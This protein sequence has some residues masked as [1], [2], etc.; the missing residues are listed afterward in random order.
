MKSMHFVAAACL[1]L[2]VSMFASGCSDTDTHIPGRFSELGE[3]CRATNDCVK[4]TACLQG[5]CV[6]AEFPIKNSA[7]ECAVIE[8]EERAD[9]NTDKRDN[10]YCSERWTLCDE[11]QNSAACYDYNRLCLDQRDCREERCVSLVNRS[12]VTTLT[13]YSGNPC[14]FG[15]SCVANETGSTLGT[16]TPDD[17]TE[18]EEEEE[19]ARDTECPLFNECQE[20]ECVRVG[21]QSD[22]E[23]ASSLRN[24]RAIC[25]KDTGKCTTPCTNDA[26]CNTGTSYSFM[27]CVKKECVYLGCESDEECRGSAQLGSSSNNLRYEC[28]KP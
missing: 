28:R 1:L 5:V 10:E 20:G 22:R 9:C 6:A 27:G 4:D 14:D 7:K 23:C 24:G 19:C 11:H 18:P 2:L 3:S 12:C 13:N 16:C 8:C 21:C 17:T 26:E 15:Y 25:V